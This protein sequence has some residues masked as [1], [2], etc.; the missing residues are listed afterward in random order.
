MGAYAAARRHRAEL[1]EILA[2]HHD[3]P[4]PGTVIGVILAWIVMSALTLII[5]GESILL[6]IAPTISFLVIWVVI[7]IMLA[8]ERL[9]VC[10]RGLL[11]GSVAPFLRPYVIRY[12]QIVPGS[13]VP[14]SGSVRR[15]A[16]Q[17]GLPGMTTVRI[18]WWSRRGVSLAGPTPAEARGRRGA[19]RPGTTRRAMPWLI[20]TRAP[21]QQ[22][23]A[24]IARGAGAAG[25]IDL[26]RATAAAPPRTLTGNPADAS[27]QLPAVNVPNA[28]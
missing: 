1:G 23:T 25:F 11:L 2:I 27:A 12:D 9:I 4:G 24:D 16:K 14:I 18:S 5:P 8:G 13:I 10:E 21:A 19:A 26:A 6:A 15:Y 7:Y 20:G 3:R 17:T 22:A 28:R